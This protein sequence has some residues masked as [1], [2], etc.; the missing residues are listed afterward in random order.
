MLVHGQMLWVSMIGRF[1]FETHVRTGLLYAHHA[2]F[3]VIVLI[4][5]IATMQHCLALCEAHSAL[6]GTQAL[7]KSYTVGTGPAVVETFWIGICHSGWDIEVKLSIGICWN[8]RPLGCASS[9]AEEVQGMLW[10]ERCTLKDSQVLD[11]IPL[12]I[13]QFHSLPAS[14]LPLPSCLNDLESKPF[15]R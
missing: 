7:A 11:F 1:C 6:F 13:S 5:V 8:D 2:F 15:R 4:H 12:P 14:A 10:F 3:G 9:A